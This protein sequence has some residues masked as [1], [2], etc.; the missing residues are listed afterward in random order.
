[1]TLC[2]NIYS[3]NPVNPPDN[4]IDMVM[5]LFN[6]PALKDLP[7]YPI[8]GNLD[9]DAQDQYFEV[10][11]TKK[12]KNWKMHELYYEKLIPIGNEKYFAVL[13][14]DSCLLLFSNYS[15]SL[16][17]TLTNKKVKSSGMSFYYNDSRNQSLVE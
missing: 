2:D 5:Q 17:D 11:M 12:Y 4:E 9:C 6:K 7:I 16:D 8:R 13:F 15:Y 10:N 3:T 1:M 14:L